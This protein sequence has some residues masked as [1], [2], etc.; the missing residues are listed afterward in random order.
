MKQC[1]KEALIVHLTK[2]KDISPF[3]WRDS[4]SIY[5]Q[6]AFILALAHLS[7]AKTINLYW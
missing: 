3:F 4:G 7:A 1:Q 5:T 2:E 6:I